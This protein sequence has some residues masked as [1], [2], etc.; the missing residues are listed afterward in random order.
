MRIF[1]QRSQIEK[2][3]RNPAVTVGSFDGVHAGH[4]AIL[5]QLREAAARQD[6]ESVVV[7]FAPHPRRVLHLEDDSLKL[8]NS[9]EEKIT[10]LEE[11]G[12]DHLWIV[13][14]TPEFSRLDS[15][16]FVRR[17]LLEGVGAKTIVLGYNHHFGHNRLGNRDFLETLKKQYHVEMVQVPKLD[18]RQQKVSSTVLRDLIARGDLQEA[19][20][21]L[22]EPYFLLAQQ[23]PDRQLIYDEPHKLF[24]PAGTYPVTV[25]ANGKSTRAE[26]RILSGNG[27]EWAGADHK[28]FSTGQKLR[29]IFQ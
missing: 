6:G 12:I 25:N 4:R 9:L 11:A 28:E 1:H 27:L 16:S 23:G 7:T 2:Q 29:I 24:P 21:L 3:V 22:S 15:E 17:Y 18:V 8:L 20:K 26:L 5:E 10:L 14:F 19:R 13:E